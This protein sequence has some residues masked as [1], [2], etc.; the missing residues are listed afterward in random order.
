MLDTMLQKEVVRNT[1]HR[2]SRQVKPTAQKACRKLV[3]KHGPKPTGPK[4]A[5]HIMGA[6]VLPLANRPIFRNS[7]PIRKVQKS[8]HS[9]MA[10]PPPPPKAAAMPP[11]PPPVHFVS[12]TK[13]SEK[14]RV[15][16]RF[17][18]EGRD[19]GAVVDAIDPYSLAWRAKLRRG[20]IILGIIY[21]GE[22]HATDSGY[23][24]AELLRPMEGKL[25]MRV[26]RARLG[27]E[28]R[29]AQR[30]QS[31]FHMLVIRS[32]FHEMRRSAVAIQ[33]QFRR[34]AAEWL[35]CEARAAARA[36]QTYARGYVARRRRRHGHG[37]FRRQIRAPACLERDDL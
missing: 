36:I 12:I 33:T 18:A 16:V 22:E 11:P 35:V 20:D 9:P 10:S 2:G 21:D 6:S 27:P 25:R 32:A 5:S 26:R 28:E 31:F 7:E 34:F 1:V 29:A 8:C 15:G 23:R 13:V 19:G 3:R 14:A 30:I 24:A 37:C 4:L 17:R